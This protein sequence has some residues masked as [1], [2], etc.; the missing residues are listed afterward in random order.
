MRSYLLL[1]MFWLLVAA[2]AFAMPNLT[3][4]DSDVSIGWVVLIFVVWNLARWWLTLP[5]KR[6]GE[7]GSRP[8][9]DS[10]KVTR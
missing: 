1:A 10:D 3:I 4:R 5:A 6:A 7:V 8:P 2:G 9:Q